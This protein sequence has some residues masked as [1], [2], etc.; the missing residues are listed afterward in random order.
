MAHIPMDRSRQGDR[1]PRLRSHLLCCLGGPVVLAFVTAEALAVEPLRAPVVRTVPVAPVQAAAAAPGVT[2]ASSRTVALV[3]GR[4]AARLVL[5]GSRLDGL[6]TAT[7]VSR[8]RA[9]TGVSA[10]LD[11]PGSPDER[12]LTLMAAPGAAVGGNYQIRLGDRRRTLD[13]PLSVVSLT[14]R[15]PGPVSAPPA[16]RLSPVPAPVPAAPV[17]RPGTMPSQAVVAPAPRTAPV[18]ASPAVAAKSTWL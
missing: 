7:V 10:R 17:T 1:S 15:A 13:V 3:P 6:E 5:R 4:P 11:P 12:S 14:V 2:G 8:N 16:A 18:P 9:V